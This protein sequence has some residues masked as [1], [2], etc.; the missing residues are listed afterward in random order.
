[1][2]TSNYTFLPNYKKFDT[3]NTKVLISSLELPYLTASLC[4]NM[5]LK[6]QTFYPDHPIIEITVLKQSFKEYKEFFKRLKKECIITEF[7]FLLNKIK[8]KL[9][10][11]IN[12]V[13]KSGFE[14][15]YYKDFPFDYRV[16]IVFIERYIKFCEIYISDIL[17]QYS[18]D[19]QKELFFGK[20]DVKTKL[21]IAR[22]HL[23]KIAFNDKYKKESESYVFGG[24][25]FGVIYKIK[26]Q[27]VKC[28]FEIEINKNEYRIAEK[29]KELINN[30]SLSETI[31]LNDF[32]NSKL[33]EKIIALN[34]LGVLN[35]LKEIEPF[36]TSI[37]RLAEFL[38]LCIGEKT[39][40]IQS[41]INPILNNSD[42]VKSPYNTSKTVD[43]I[44]QKLIQIGCNIKD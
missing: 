22:K 26:Q 38:S 39:T 4:L 20:Y 27:D 43:I 6:Y 2:S 40:S 3:Q 5:G 28:F 13:V 24:Y 33:T 23:E 41:Y 44:R 30:F 1:M 29:Q 34:E 19:L 25:D 18:F 10:S 11:H 15:D 32:S 36:N 16:V 8:N 14:N 7:I 9:E 42:K 37:N 21:D 31:H 12:M 35:Y 17:Y